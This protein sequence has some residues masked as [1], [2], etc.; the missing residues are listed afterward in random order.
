MHTRCEYFARLTEPGRNLELCL[1]EVVNMGKIFAVTILALG[2]C[3]AH[4]NAAEGQFS[5][6]AGY[7][8]PGNVNLNSVRTGLDLRGTS[9]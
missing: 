9:L 1:K 8:N 7:L 2:F 3:V 6:Y 5:L 4:A